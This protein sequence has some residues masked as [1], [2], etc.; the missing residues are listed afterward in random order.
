M[1]HFTPK[2]AREL[3]AIVAE[4]VAREEPMELIAGGSKQGLG[5]PLQLPHVLDLSAFAGIRNYEPEELVLTAGAATPLAAIEAALKEKRQM[6]AFEPGDW[7]A[8]FGTATATPT[9]GGVIACSL[10]GPRRIRVGA[11][12]DHLLGFHAVSGRGESFKAGGRVVKNVTGYDLPKLMAGSYGTLA[13][14]TEVTLKVLPAPEATHTLAVLGLDDEA[15]RRAMGAALSSPHEVTGAAHFPA[16]ISGRPRTLLRIEGHGPSVEARSAALRG[17]LAAFGAV[18]VLRGP[19]AEEKWRALRDL[20]FFVSLAD[21]ALWRLSVP[22]ASGPGVAARVAARLDAKHVFDWG[23]GLLWLAV[24]GAE[25]GGAAIIRD[26]VA[27]GHATLIRASDSIRSAVPV[28]QPQPP[29]LAALT[30]RVKS[31]FDPRR[32]LNR[33]RMYRDL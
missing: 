15:A 16:W 30:A 9:L 3:E 22:P 18:E 1:T 14:L 29:A 27:P 31:Q 17:E 2:D 21:R 11:A 6:L 32:I 8:L 19:E 7:R 10:S 23:G 12:R 24:A 33:G 25:D 4:G 28:F 26:A 20:A 13:A 5:R